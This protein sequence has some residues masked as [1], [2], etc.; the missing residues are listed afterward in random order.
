MWLSPPSRSVDLPAGCAFRAF[1]C[2]ERRERRDCLL[3][4]V[5]AAALRE[6]SA[7]TSPEDLALVHPDPAHLMRLLSDMRYVYNVYEMPWP[8]WRQALEP[9]SPAAQAADA[10]DREHI[11]EPLRWLC[12]NL[13]DA[14]RVAY[15]ERRPLVVVPG[16]G[17]HHAA[18]GHAE[19]SNL[20]C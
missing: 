18:P 10:Q 13:V 12:A 5:P 9:G 4:L 6:A 14:T 20:F 2:C 1:P 8:E 15:E 19:G 16:A 3:G 7:P 11:I 17:A